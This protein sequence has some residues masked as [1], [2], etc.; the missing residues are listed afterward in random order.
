M[1]GA[2]IKIEV[3]NLK[4]KV[5]VCASSYNLNKLPTRCNSLSSFIT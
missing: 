1:H 5:R 3:N 2:T 4:F